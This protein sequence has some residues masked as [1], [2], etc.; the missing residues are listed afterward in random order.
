MATNPV[1]VPLGIITAGCWLALRF[2]LRVSPVPAVVLRGRARARLRH[3]RLSGPERSAVVLHHAAEVAL[4]AC[5]RASAEG[6]TLR[7]G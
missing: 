6:P 5:D 4:E 3:C 2:G 1:T 7:P